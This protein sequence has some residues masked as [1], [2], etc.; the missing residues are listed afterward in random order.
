[1]KELEAGEVIDGLVVKQR[2]GSGGMGEV[3]LVHDPALAVDRAL[4]LISLTGPGFAGSKTEGDEYRARFEREARTLARLRHENIIPVHAVGEHEGAPYLVMSYFPSK[5]ARCWLRDE[6]PTLERIK[7]VG[8]QVARAVAHAHEAGALHRDIK[9]ANI[10]VG[11][12]DE[13]MLIDFGLAKSIGDDDLTRTGRSMGTF[14]YLAPEYVRASTVGKAVHTQA[15]DLWA[16]GCVLYALTC[17]TPVFKEKNEVR[18]LQLVARGRYVP[19]NV[20]SPDVPDEWASLIHALLEPDPAQRMPSAAELAR[21]IERSLCAGAA[22]TAQFG[23][24]PVPEFL[25]DP[26]QQPAA[27]RSLP[28]AR[29]TL[30]EGEAPGADATPP[31]A[32]ERF[33]DPNAARPPTADLE[34]YAEPIVAA[35]G[36]LDSATTEALDADADSSIMAHD[37][38]SPTALRRQATFLP[39]PSFQLPPERDASQRVSARRRLILPLAAALAVMAIGGA[40]ILW[41]THAAAKPGNRVASIDDHEAERQRRATVEIEELERERDAR[42]LERDTARAATPAAP[43]PLFAAAIEEAQ[44][45]SAGLVSDGNSQRSP[46][47]VAAQ[48]GHGAHPAPPDPWAARYGSRTSYNTSTAAAQPDASTASARPAA[49]PI[50]GVRV[51][52]RVTDAIASAPAGPVIAVV[53]APT[54]VGAIELPRGAELHGRTAGVEGARILLQFSFA[55]VNGRNVAL[56]GIALGHDGRPGIAGEKSLGGLSDIAADAAGGAAQALL[57]GAAAV[58][59]NDV[60]RRAIQGATASTVAKTERLDNEEQLVVA[61]RSARFFVY[62][63]EV[64]GA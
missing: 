61:Q 38:T 9:L 26:A 57:G 20:R 3:Y 24:A 29:G 22:P 16:I 11:K 59:P 1:M 53:Q 7:R 14:S 25:A 5:D 56:K 27:H 6:A 48:S 60:A 63:E 42:R 43:V 51:P 55:I 33:V 4:K 52:V 49:A 12:G 64:P 31:M 44:P 39:Q 23:P 18:L 45:A 2:I 19:V 54:R 36:D 62:I 47:R 46:E 13:V 15:T 21:R 28:V 50:A 40:L 10:L 58:V 34:Q 32:E 35:S 8:L 17:R 37:D 41:T 30:A